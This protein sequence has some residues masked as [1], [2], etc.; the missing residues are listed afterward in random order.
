MPVIAPPT[1]RLI[2]GELQWTDRSIGE[3]RFT[4]LLFGPAPSAEALAAWATSPF[5]R[6][7]RQRTYFH[8][9]YAGMGTQQTWEIPALTEGEYSVRVCA[10][11]PADLDGYQCAAAVRF[12]SLPISAKMDGIRSRIRPTFPRGD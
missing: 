7:V 10:R 4:I 3:D 6:K 12:S 9:A 11:F 2:G 1:S 5:Q 8:G